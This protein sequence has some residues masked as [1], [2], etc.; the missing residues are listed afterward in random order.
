MQ[1]VMHQYGTYLLPGLPTLLPRV[2]RNRGKPLT[3]MFSP[4]RP[5]RLCFDPFIS[6]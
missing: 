4:E 1:G 3:W 5:L 6:T 2:F